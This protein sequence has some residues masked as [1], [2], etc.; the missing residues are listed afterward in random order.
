MTGYICDYQDLKSSFKNNKF[1][2]VPPIGLCNYD[3]F[4]LESHC[5]QLLSPY[6]PPKKA[7]DPT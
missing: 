1:P 7:L 3:Y 5:S 4:L 6:L 2:I